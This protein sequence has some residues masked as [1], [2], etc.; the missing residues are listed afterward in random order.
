MVDVGA[1]GEYMP[2]SAA[3]IS[4]VTAIL[5]ENRY[6][7]IPYYDVPLTGQGVA[8][9][10]DSPGSHY[11][12]NYCAVH[13]PGGDPS[14]GWE[15]EVLGFF[16]EQPPEQPAERPDIQQLRR[17]LLTFHLGSAALANAPPVIN[18]FKFNDA[19]TAI[20]QDIANA[21]EFCTK[22]QVPLSIISLQTVVK[23][24]VLPKDSHIARLYFPVFI[25]PK[26]ALY[27]L[28]RLVRVAIQEEL[29]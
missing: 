8:D 17:Q 6:E 28:K 4:R 2:V 22:V 20:G 15:F 19:G 12:Q 16:N 27:H 24:L 23:S 25:P 7:C 29:F 26:P 5:H 10:A 14:R 18:L 13:W 3:N 21:I 1:G 11:D 9:V